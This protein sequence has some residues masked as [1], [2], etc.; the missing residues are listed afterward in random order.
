MQ[1][2]LHKCPP[3]SYVTTSR[4]SNESSSHIFHRHL[5][6]IPTIRLLRMCLFCLL[7][8]A[9]SLHV[10]FITKHKFYSRAFLQILLES[11]VQILWQFTVNQHL[12]N[13]ILLYMLDSQEW[14]QPLSVCRWL[15]FIHMVF[16]ITGAE[17]IFIQDFSKTLEHS[18]QTLKQIL[19][20]MSFD[21]C[22]YTVIESSIWVQYM[23][24]SLYLS[25]YLSFYLS[26]VLL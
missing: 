10:T 3:I 19:E 6:R 15:S 16:T 26:M 21:Y 25:I 13:A 17:D 8:A 23:K 2:T 11:K 22:I 9:V 12:L 14:Y 7:G 5:T 18:L 4:E 24:L 20:E 1:H